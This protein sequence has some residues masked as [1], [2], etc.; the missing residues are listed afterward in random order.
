MALKWSVRQGLAWEAHFKLNEFL[1]IRVMICGLSGADSHQEPNALILQF[2]CV[3]ADAD[4][5]FLN[6]QFEFA[7]SC[8]S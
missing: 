6:S 3:L 4:P 1:G 8:F 7:R 2:F 5:H